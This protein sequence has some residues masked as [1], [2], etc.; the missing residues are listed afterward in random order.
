MNIGGTPTA[1]MIA[2]WLGLTT[3]VS[4]AAAVIIA[5]ALGFLL[6]ILPWYLWRAGDTE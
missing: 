5:L 4:S 1:K 2:E 6:S 3:D